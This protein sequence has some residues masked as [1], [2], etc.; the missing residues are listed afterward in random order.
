VF[1]IKKLFNTKTLKEETKSFFFF[2]SFGAED[3]QQNN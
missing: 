1:F 3:G 2:F